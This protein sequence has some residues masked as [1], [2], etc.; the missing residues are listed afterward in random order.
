VTALRTVQLTEWKLFTAPRGV[1]PYYLGTE[2]VAVALLLVLPGRSVTVADGA[3]FAALLAF[4]VLQA[5]LSRQVEKIR[6]YFANV[7]HVN[8]TSVWI[9]AGALLLPPALAALLALMIYGHLWTRVWRTI[10]SRPAYRVV[11]SATTMI[12][13]CLVV[14]PTLRALGTNG[15]PDSSHGITSLFA[16][17]AAGVAFTVVNS[18]LIMVGLKL[19]APQRLFL[20]LIGSW[21]DNALELGTLCLGGVTAALLATHPFLVPLV[22]LPVVVLHRCVLV[23]QLE[24]MATQDA[25][26]GLLTD[27]EWRSRATGELVRA[28]QEEDHCGVLMID[29]DHFKRVNDTYGHLAGDAALKAVADT[30]RAEVRTYDSVGRFGGEEFVVLLPGIRDAHSVAIAERI[31]EAVTRIE[32]RTPLEDAT[33]AGLSVSIGV[34]SYPHAGT[35]LDR[36]LAAADQA[37][38]RAKY[39]GRNQVVSVAQAP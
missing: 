32:V 31:R 3:W 29:L 11:F 28:R 16:I 4:G 35:V 14:P 34:A 15:F 23:R 36:L 1:L 37:L 2:V 12:V 9:F 38:Y 5:E 26:T 19:H 22:L 7:P 18:L 39:S 30:V 8:M 21:S 20:P 10:S 25:K 13:A 6:R 17:A 24:E 27:A 33:I